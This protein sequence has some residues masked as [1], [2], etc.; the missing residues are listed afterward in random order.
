MKNLFY[1]FLLLAVLSFVC[2]TGGNTDYRMLDVCAQKVYDYPNSVEVLL[3]EISEDRLQ[4]E[5]E[6]RYLLIKM[7]VQDALDKPFVSLDTVEMVADYYNRKGNP[8]DRV[9][10]NYLMGRANYLSGDVLKAT[11]CYN[12]CLEDS[13]STDDAR[14]NILLSK[15]HSQ[16]SLIYHEQKIPDWEEQEIRW[17]MFYAERADDTLLSLIYRQFLYG[18]YYQRNDHEGVV[19]VVKEV[20]GM[21]RDMGR[22]TEAARMC[23]ILMNSYLELGDYVSAKKIWNGTDDEPAVLSILQDKRK[24][25]AETKLVFSLNKKAEPTY[26]IGGYDMTGADFSGNSAAKNG[27]ITFMANAGRNGIQVDPSTFTL[28]LF[29][30]F[31]PASVDESF[32]NGLYSKPAEKYNQYHKEQDSQAEILYS[33]A[34][35]KK[36]SVEAFTQTVTL[37]ESITNGS[38]Y[39]FA[40]TGS[41]LDGLT[42]ETSEGTF[43]GFTGIAAGTPPQVTISFPDDDAVIKSS[44]GLFITGTASSAE[45]KIKEISYEITVYDYLKKDSKG[46]YSKVGTITGFAEAVENTRFGDASVKYSCDVSKGTFVSANTNAYPSANPGTGQI[47][48]YEIV[49]VRVTTAFPSA[50][51]VVSMSSS[52]DASG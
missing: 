26:S 47:F 4:G 20:C 51:S 28:Y 46:N 41:D 35:Y 15:V 29:G 42:L 45:S 24:D 13:V 38:R 6:K 43:Y 8:Q 27:K 25:T 30:P 5:S 44:E 31:E 2:C 37:P 3:N 16:L 32:I 14:F 1:L 33:G 50:R 22:E 40:A 36:G 52:N 49:V 39:I 11:E 7:M 18:P 34:D 23:T 19:K 21:L 48:V 9:N 10:A 17:A 12:R